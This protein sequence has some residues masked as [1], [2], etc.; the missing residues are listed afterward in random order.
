M[1]NDNVIIL[2]SIGFIINILIFMFNIEFISE[3]WSKA[4]LS[5]KFKLLFI[6]ALPLLVIASLSYRSL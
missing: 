1:N 3:Q 6:G 2:F 4:S 5:N